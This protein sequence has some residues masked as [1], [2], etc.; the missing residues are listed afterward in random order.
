MTGLQL[1]KSIVNI[2]V[3]TRKSLDVR[4]RQLET[5][6]KKKKVD[7]EA[8]NQLEV[9]AEELQEKVNQLEDLIRD[10]FNGYYLFF[11]IAFLSYLLC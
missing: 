1:I 8:A 6:Q 11:F 5:A 3:E 9:Q 10:L 2:T 7:E 4:Q